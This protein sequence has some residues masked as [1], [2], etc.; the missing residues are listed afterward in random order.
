MTA[1][2]S[3]GTVTPPISR[4]A[5]L[6]PQQNAT[7]VSLVWWANNGT[8]PSL[9]AFSS[10]SGN[11][12]STDTTDYYAAFPSHILFGGNYYTDA[13]YTVPL[14]PGQSTVFNDMYIPFDAGD[15]SVSTNLVADT[16][17]VA[18][19]IFS[20]VFAWQTGYN[21]RLDY[22]TS[23][24]TGTFTTQTPAGT[25]GQWLNPYIGANVGLVGQSFRVTKHNVPTGAGTGSVAGSNKVG[26]EKYDGRYYTQ[27]G[28]PDYMNYK[29]GAY[30]S[31]VGTYQDRLCYA[32]FVSNPG[33]L[34]FSNVGTSDETYF[35]SK[36]PHMNF[37][38]NY[39]DPE[40]ATSPLT[41]QLNLKA[42]EKI[43]C[44]KQWY[45]DL[46]VG[47]NT[48][49]YRVHGGDNLAITPS[50]FYVS[51]VA[52]VGT[53]R[54]GMTLTEDGVVFLSESGVYKI[55]LDVNT[56]AYNTTNIGLKIRPEIR[57]A[58][59]NNRFFNSIGRIAY[60]SANNV[61]YV[62][63]GNEYNSQTPSR[64]FVYFADREAWSEYCMYN[65]FMNAQAVA[66]IDG[67]VFMGV[68]GTTSTYTSLAEFNID[69]LFNDLQSEKT[70]SDATDIGY[71]LDDTLISWNRGDYVAGSDVVLTL[72]GFVKAIPISNVDYLN[73]VTSS[74]EVGVS[75]T[76]YW[77]HRGNSLVV[78]GTT[79]WDGSEVLYADVIQRETNNYHY[80]NVYSVADEEY[81]G[82]TDLEYSDNMGVQAVVGSGYDGE[83]VITNLSYPTWWISP[84]FTRN[85]IKNLKR[86]HHFYGIFQN[87]PLPVNRTYTSPTWRG[88]NS[89]DMTLVQNG[90]L[91]G[92]TEFYNMA[93]DDVRDIS[94]DAP[95]WLDYFR[96]SI[97]VKGNFMSFQACVHSF[98]RGQWELVGYQIDTE[99]EGRTSRRAYNE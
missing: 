26:V 54:N 3:V 73:I 97:P 70:L 50:N 2:L 66:C 86:M 17:R 72:G 35:T 59:D 44:M 90:T 45:D 32:G 15:G 12:P 7:N 82:L 92:A 51:K 22:N 96:V 64:C 1:T 95:A 23:D 55:F 79:F 65:G 31:V 16:D 52:S 18:V 67:R 84:A 49:I 48:D 9:G 88:L 5:Y 37:E 58:M 43:V 21:M 87:T 39:T 56:G 47:T 4:S 6:N 19:G 33:T 75:G 57:K 62:L 41:V 34:L 28:L 38:V 85:D 53:V 94:N 42:G 81:L 30:A 40:L 98:D 74:S 83:S 61:I 69:N 11:T 20:G 60:D 24:A 29:T 14:Q 99:M 78:N 77:Q 91:G 76:D 93:S 27:Y 46:F 71:D 8:R 80:L 89:F 36:K 25:A 10:V 68:R 13:A 63:V